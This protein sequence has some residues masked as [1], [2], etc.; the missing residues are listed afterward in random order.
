MNKLDFHHHHVASVSFSRFEHTVY[1]TQLFVCG[2]QSHGLYALSLWQGYPYLPPSSFRASFARTH[3]VSSSFSILA[4]ML[5][6]C[7]QWRLMGNRLPPHAPS[8][9]RHLQQPARGTQCSWL[10]K[11]TPTHSLSYA[12]GGPRFASCDPR[13]TSTFFFAHDNTVCTDTLLLPLACLLLPD[14]PPYFFP[15]APIAPDSGLS[16]MYGLRTPPVFS[17]HT[18]TRDYTIPRV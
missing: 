9:D 3:V 15:Q 5:L 4:S 17:T 16:S 10:N 14:L 6:R 12:R 11:H 8:A 1:Y 2:L 7:L 13:I 18:D